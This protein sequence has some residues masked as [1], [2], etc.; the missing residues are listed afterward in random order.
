[1]LEILNVRKGHEF[2]LPLASSFRKY[3]I[4]S[5]DKDVPKWA[6]VPVPSVPTLISSVICST[7]RPWNLPASHLNQE[8]RINKMLGEERF[9]IGLGRGWVKNITRL[10]HGRMELNEG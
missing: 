3:T 2:V 5:T 10:V 4:V 8:D 1:M 6:L 9:P 7:S